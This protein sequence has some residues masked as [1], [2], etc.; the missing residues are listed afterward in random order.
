MSKLIT[1]NL[2]LFNVDNFI[3]SFVEPNYNI[4]YY[5]LANPRPFAQDSTPPTLYSN[6][7]TIEIDT[8]D[9]MICGKRI[10]SSDVARMTLRKNWTSGV[11]YT[12]YAHDAQNLETADY[13]VVHPESG[14][15]HV[16]KC[17]DNNNGA[18]STSAPL[19]SQTSADDDFYFTS[20]GYQW[21]YMYSIT[22][23]EFDKFATSS[24]M[25]VFVNANV[26]GNAVSG[27][28]QSIQ[29][30]NKGSG[31]ASYCNGFF[32]EVRVGGNPLVYALDS[33]TASS[34]SNFYI[35]SAI[36][37][38]SGPG[39][40][41]QR[42]ITGYTVSG[43][44]R[45]VIVDTPF[46]TAPTTS[47]KYEISPLVQVSG[48][49]SGATARAVVNASSNTIQSVEIVDRGEGYTYATV[50]ITGNT[51]VINVSSNSTT[52]NTAT[53]KVIISPKGGHGSNAA[54]ELNSR[55]V[56]ISSEFDS[57]LSG[58]KVVD[59]NDFRV[60]GILKDPLFANVVLDIS[61]GTGEFEDGE[62]VYQSQ[63]APIAGIVITNP[64]SGYS[65]NATV[66]ITGSSSVSAVA[67][68]SSNSSGRISQINISNTGQGYISPSI[69]ISAPAAQTFN[70][71]TSVS[72]TDDFIT[73]SNNVFQNNDTVKY[74]V[75]VG[76]TAVSGLS[77]NTTYYVVQA[78]STGIKLSSSLNGSAINLTAGAS[79]TGHSLTGNTATA[80]AVVDTNKITTAYGI[81][82][83]ANSSVVKMT[84]AYG[85]FVTG[86]STTSVLTGN[87]SG[88]TATC[89]SVTQPST[90]FDQTYKVLGTME[91]SEFQEDELIT[92]PT[93]TGN[94]Y[95]YSQSG[96]GANTR[97]VRLVNKR[98]TINQSDL[99]VDYTIE[100]STS[101]ARMQ[102][103]SLVGSDLVHGT[104]DV[105]YIENFSP[106]NK[107][108]GQTETIKLILKF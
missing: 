74:L 39:S 12:P 82:T 40:G 1:N 64:G 28:I 86:N 55:Y 60:V 94:G 59:E 93:T 46:S 31:Y 78:N 25:P 21:K 53:A 24:Y 29:V 51:G 77:N 27:S 45:R 42:V 32:Q 69:T 87:T 75:A 81:V 52:T 96:A 80:V 13:Y 102:V 43:S 38:S 50:T 97:T 70:S 105:I 84:N 101:A 63:G 16:F 47:S 54:A 2:K 90:Y 95:F 62:V 71:N 22:S 108:T 73:I 49:G 57:T 85:I 18:N 37:I 7:Q 4:Y 79:E 26:V 56:G 100:G 11:V 34:N 14:S 99:S 19:L 107:N 106:V 91:A 20:D 10:T 9:N 33:S 92:Q 8:Y 98:G 48:D 66:T 36:K 88:Y 76:N 104:G 17:I 3:E 15:Y 61:S 35:N 30:V 68:A 89:D 103:S 5:F 67:N 72:N 83:F 23:T 44:T 41:Q 58:D 65:S 6:P